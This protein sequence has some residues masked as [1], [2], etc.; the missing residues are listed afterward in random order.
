MATERLEHWLKST[1][2]G[3]DDI[4]KILTKQRYK[5]LL[6]KYRTKRAHGEMID[7]E[8]I[9][10]TIETIAPDVEYRKM[11]YREGMEEQF[12]HDIH[13]WKFDISGVKVWISYECPRNR[14]HNARPWEITIYS[15]EPE[16]IY[17]GRTSYEEGIAFLL[18]KWTTESIIELLRHLPEHINQWKDEQELQ[19][20]LTE[21]GTIKRH[22]WQ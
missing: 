19:N 20:R 1:R 11:L 10:H 2:L 13:N 16:Y 15:D 6:L 22:S 8:R 9:K 4:E 21:D 7:F 3:Y 14:N 12:V 5:E 17:L 18:S